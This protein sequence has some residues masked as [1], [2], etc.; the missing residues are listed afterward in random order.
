[1][2]DQ[3]FYDPPLAACRKRRTAIPLRLAFD[4]IDA[5]WRA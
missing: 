2:F 1:M 4:R 5:A 3:R